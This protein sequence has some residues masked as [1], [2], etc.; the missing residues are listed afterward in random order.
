V[1]F[2]RSEEAGSSPRRRPFIGSSRANEK[3]S[4]NVCPRGTISGDGETA[5]KTLWSPIQGLAAILFALMGA[6]AAPA[7]AETCESLAHR[8]VAAEG[9]VIV[10]V[11]Q[12]DSWLSSIRSLTTFPFRATRC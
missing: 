6:T 1:D 8:I 3:S 5:E 12:P 9:G 10:S 11:R 2:N 4:S 7:Y